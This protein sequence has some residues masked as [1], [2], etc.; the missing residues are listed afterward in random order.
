M[1]IQCLLSAFLEKTFN[2][3]LKDATFLTPEEM[4]AA[5]LCTGGKL[6]DLR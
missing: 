3:L 2:F 1:I 5:E 4:E 6:D